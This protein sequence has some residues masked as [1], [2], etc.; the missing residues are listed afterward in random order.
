MRIQDIADGTSNTVFCGEVRE[1]FRPWGHPANWRDP[2]AGINQSP[3]GFGSPVADGCLF[4]MGDGTV[5]LVNKNI[6]PNML[7]ALATPDGGED[8]PN[9]W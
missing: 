2:A 1:R 7:K 5:R 9:D 6:A 3:E 8:V 4:L